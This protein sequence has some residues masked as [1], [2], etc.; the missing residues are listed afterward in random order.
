MRRAVQAWSSCE[1]CLQI[2]LTSCPPSAVPAPRVAE[3]PQTDSQ[4]PRGLSTWRPRAGRQGA[5]PPPGTVRKDGQACEHAS[6]PLASRL[7]EKSS[8][9]S[10]P[11]TR[12]DH[13]NLCPRRR[14]MGS[15]SSQRTYVET[16]G[17][18]ACL[19]T[20]VPGGRRAFPH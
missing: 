19:V 6:L 15:T 4:Q 3:Q 16:C 2:R 5:C 14:R 13:S 9:F 18:G 1:L 7:L 17:K 12:S 11:P 20:Q 8:G 10:R